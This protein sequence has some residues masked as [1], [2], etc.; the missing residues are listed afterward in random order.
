MRYG[1]IGIFSDRLT[2]EVHEQQD[3]RFF[4]LYSRCQPLYLSSCL[5]EGSFTEQGQQLLAEGISQLL[6]DAHLLLCQKAL[7]FA[8]S[9]LR[10]AANRE[11]VCQ[12]LLHLFSLPVTV[13]T[14]QEQCC[15]SAQELPDSAA[16]SGLGCCIGGESVQIFSYRGKQ[17]VQWASLPTGYL[18]LKRR[19]VPSLFPTAAEEQQM[20]QDLLPLLEGYPHFL[21]TNHRTL[22]V[23]GFGAQQAALLHLSFSGNQPGF[24]PS[25]WREGD[26][27][28]V[29]QLLRSPNLSGAELVQK[30]FPHFAPCLF[31]TLIL[32][33]A[34]GRLTGAEEQVIYPSSLS[35]PFLQQHAELPVES[36]EITA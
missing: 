9:V 17:L 28:L 24:G 21:K 11:E 23:T 20:E 7:A 8:T 25:L 4:K 30:L 16:G 2:L 18:S 34:I 31:P 33:R 10:Y 22:H 26:F 3:G 36:Q 6:E 13:L 19:F 12:K 1:I 14:G 15:F 5:E 29:F 32:M 27:P 35:G